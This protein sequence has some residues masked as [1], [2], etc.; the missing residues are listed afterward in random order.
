MSENY[1]EFWLEQNL[2]YTECMTVKCSRPAEKRLTP[3]T[4]GKSSILLCKD[5]AKKFKRNHSSFKFTLE[6]ASNTPQIDL[7][8][9][10][11][12]FA[13]SINVDRSDNIAILRSTFPTNPQV[14][15]IEKT[16]FAFC[17]NRLTFATE[18]AKLFYNESGR[19]VSFMLLPLDES[20][21]VFY[22]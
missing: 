5:C 19:L 3:K 11:Q 7:P 21:Q 4:G 10:S 20:S 12:D 17:D 16:F 1:S 18:K 14:A 15:E 2:H 22:L 6:K 9:Q 8:I 13:N